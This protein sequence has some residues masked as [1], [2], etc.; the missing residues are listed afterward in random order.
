MKD[1][2]L[3]A[4]DLQVFH[5]TLAASHRMRL[6]VELLDRDENVVSTLTAP[7]HL[8]TSGEVQIDTTA[9]ITR[10]LSL[11]LVDKGRRLAFDPA[12]SSDT[13]VWASNFVRVWRCVYCPDLA[14]DEKWV[15]VPVFC[16]PITKFKRQ[17][18]SV[19]I[20]AM[21]KEALGLAPQS[22]WR[23]YNIPRGTKTTDAIRR[24]LAAIGETK[25][26]FG[27]LTIRHRLHKKLAMARGQEPWKIAKKLAE[28][29]VDGRQLFYDGEG[30]VRLRPVPQKEC[31]TFT[32][33]DGGTVLAHPGVEYDLSAVRNVVTIT[34]GKPR[35]SK[36]TVS[37]T[38][39]AKKADPLSPQA[40][41]RNGKPR[42]LTYKESHTSIKTQAAAKSKALKVLKE[43]ERA[44]IN[45]DFQSLVVAHLE[46][47]DVCILQT[48]EYRTP[49]TMRQWA[50]PLTADGSMSLGVNRRVSFARVL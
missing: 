36:K 44:A 43:K 6:I 41:A 35:G 24:I 8:V 32:T 47:L 40:L 34:G 20:E 29:A 15:D 7:A 33:G 9:A 46:E 31:F 17:H 18:P 10:S 4:D 23:S 19:T 45:V 37:Y 39:I 27:E 25:W 50:I 26:G 3:S 30:R 16:G 11:E 42:Y 28:G 38:A 1:L 21:G 48:S 12:S 5:A 2:G 14:R 49:F 13:G 22:V